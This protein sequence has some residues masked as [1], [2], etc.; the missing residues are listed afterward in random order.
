MAGNVLKGWPLGSALEDSAPFAPGV[1]IATGAAVKFN[2]AGQLVLATGA[3]LEVAFQALDT[4]ASSDVI[5]SGKLPFIIG[6]AICSTDQIVT[7]TSPSPGQELIIGLGANA[8][9]LKVRVL[10]GEATQP[11]YGWFQ[12][13]MVIEGINHLVYIK[14]VPNGRAQ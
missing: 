12:R 3:A 9:R 11:T 10:P 1:T 14:M 5:S 7:G 6:N 2:A 8:G 4:T 13:F